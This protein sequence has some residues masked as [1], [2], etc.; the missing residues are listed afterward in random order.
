MGST[1]FYRVS[2]SFTGFL[3][4][5]YVFLMKITGFYQVLMGFT[6][7]YRFSMVF[8]GY[9]RVLPGFN[10]FYWVLPGFT[11][12]SWTSLG[13][14]WFYRVSIGLLG[15]YRFSMGF[16]WTLPGFTRFYQVSMCFT[17][18]YRVLPSFTEFYRVLLSDTGFYR[19]ELSCKRVSLVFLERF[20]VLEMRWVVWCF[21]DALLT[22][23]GAPRTP[24]LAPGGCC[25]VRGA[26]LAEGGG[27]LGAVSSGIPRP[28]LRPPAPL[29]FYFPAVCFCWLWLWR[30]CFVF[31]AELGQQTAWPR[32]R[33]ENDHH[34]MASP[35]TC[36]FASNWTLGAF[37]LSARLSLSLSLSLLQSSLSISY[38][39]RAYR[40]QIWDESK[41]DIN[42]KKNAQPFL[43]SC[44][45]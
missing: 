40:E 8:T 41:K 34:E 11:E 36:P 2:M 10:Q 13:F 32:T 19:V 18:I 24:R 28:T 42:V 37:R 38:F 25:S 12:F 20:G 14:T 9:Y 35:P 44:F 22:V 45:F 3:P 17:R 31:D 6:R 5:F 39:Y 4:V 21:L 26:G 30:F 33:K 27:A 16:Y 15:F 29:R 23:L 7:F 43:Y 1:G